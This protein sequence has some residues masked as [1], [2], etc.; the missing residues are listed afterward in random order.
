MTHIPHYY[1]RVINSSLNKAMKHKVTI[2][3][4][5]LIAAELLPTHY[6]ITITS[7]GMAPTVI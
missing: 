3:S 4:I 6:C 1:V 5:Q 2:Q 7:L